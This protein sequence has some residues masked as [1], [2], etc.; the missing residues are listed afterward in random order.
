MELRDDVLLVE[1]RHLARIH[2][3]INFELFV[4]LGCRGNFEPL[5]HYESSKT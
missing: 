2:C 4:A 5:H 1:F 3:E